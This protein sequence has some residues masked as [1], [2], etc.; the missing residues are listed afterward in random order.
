MHSSPEPGN[1]ALVAALYE[2]S[3]DRHGHDAKPAARK[4]NATFWKEKQ[5][6]WMFAQ[7]WQQGGAEFTARTHFQGVLC[8]QAMCPLENRA[9]G[10]GCRLSVLLNTRMTLGS[11]AWGGGL[12]WS[13]SQV[14]LHFDKLKKFKTHSGS[15]SRGAAAAVAA[16]A[17]H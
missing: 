7:V 11:S 8:T 10:R 6:A 4:S 12:V 2:C 17:Q 15:S 3:M 9:T 1:L 16:A 14:V 13:V 5:K